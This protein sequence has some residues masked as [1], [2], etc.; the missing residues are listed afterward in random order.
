MYQSQQGLA[1]E[2]RIGNGNSSHVKDAP[3]EFWKPEL[4]MDQ[5]D[6]LLSHL[7]IADNFDLLGHSWGGMLAGHYAAA[8]IPGGLKKLIISNSP[9][10]TELFERGTDDLLRSQF[11]PEFYDQ[12]KKH[13]LEGTT[14]SKEYHD[15]VGLFMKN[16]VCKVD[17]WPEV[18]MQSLGEMQKDNT[19]YSKMWGPNE[20]SI[21]GTLKGWSITD[22]LHRINVPTLVISAPLDEVQLPAV[23]P[24]FLSIPKVKWVELQNSTHLA[25]FEEPEKYFSV[26]LTFLERS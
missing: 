12:M 8:R 14:D 6:G 1:R 17:P 11:P 20:F 9:V 19:V 25:Q 23:L 4:F 7:G 26:L 21:T 16:H 18:F 15:G 13:E 10:S 3:N 5:L 22:I 24:W 2:S